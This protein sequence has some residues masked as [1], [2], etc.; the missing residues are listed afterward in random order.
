MEQGKSG[1]DIKGM[2]RKKIYEFLRKGRSVSKQDIVYALQ[3][4][5]PTVTQNLQELQEK[6]LLDTAGKIGNTGGRNATAFTFISDAKV[7]VGIDIQKHH[8]TVVVVDLDGKVIETLR[9]QVDFSMTDEYYRKLGE[10]VGEI[11]EKTRTDPQKVLGVGLGVPGLISGDGQEV[12]Y[13]RILNFTGETCAN[14]S[15]YIP[16][17]SLLYNDANAAGFAEIWSLHNIENAFY[18]C[19]SNNIGGSVLLDNKV[20]EGDN[21]RSGEVGHMTVVADGR[22]CYCGQYGCLETYCSATVLSDTTCGDLGAFFEKL[23]GGDTESKLLWDSYLRY[24]S[25]AV[26]N[27]RMLFDCKIIIGGY[28]GAYIDGYMEQ[29]WEMVRQRN[30]F[31][32]D[33][34]RFLLPCQYKT[35]AIAAGAALPFV[36]EFFEQI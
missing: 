1:M 33:P 36:A 7:A 10:A 25:L 27:L 32:D 15:K 30:M 23:G 19:L 5:L 4:S 26:N 13:G 2:N 18:I 22:P 9:K 29:L 3:L 11:V 21:Q 31:G 16:Y 14:F 34:E 35:E 20:Y 17:R 12:V 6:G 8:S 24:L 28:V